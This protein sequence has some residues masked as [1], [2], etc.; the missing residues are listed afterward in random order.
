M[1]GN[2]I[3]SNYCSNSSFATTIMSSNNDDVGGLPPVIAAEESAEVENQ[4]SKPETS[5]NND[6]DGM[7]D[8]EDAGYDSERVAIVM[9]TTEDASDGPTDDEGEDINDSEGIYR[10]SGT[11]DYYDEDGEPAIG[12]GTSTGRRMNCSGS[13]NF[14]A[15]SDF[16][17]SQQSSSQSSMAERR[18][19]IRNL[20]QDEF[21]KNGARFKALISDVVRIVADGMKP[22][23]ATGSDGKEMNDS[24]V[25]TIM[26]SDNLPMKTRHTDADYAHVRTVAKERSEE[27]LALKRVRVVS[28]YCS[29][30][31]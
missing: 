3:H 12:S 23:N 31:P 4:Q 24:S 15:K 8:A 16:S 19:S 22:S 9:S 26:D 25:V 7:E 17:R 6:D 11:D 13:D 18:T 10:K 1:A 30:L 21:V 5:R 29:Y 27:C 2:G 14:K 20:K 28:I